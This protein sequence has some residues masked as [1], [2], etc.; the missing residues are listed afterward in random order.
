MQKGEN[1][2]G[3]AQPQGCLLRQSLNRYRFYLSQL[4][5]L[6]LGQYK[7]IELENSV[8][9]VTDD[10]VEVQIEYEMQNYMEEPSEGNAKA[11]NGDLIT[12]KP[13]KF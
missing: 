5:Y 13:D 10:D 12:I 6:K 9:E 8:Q 4:K 2:C 11:Q 7:G 3:Y 1:G